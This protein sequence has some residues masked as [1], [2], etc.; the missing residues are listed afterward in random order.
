[1]P[2]LSG[3]VKLETNYRKQGKPIMQ[4]RLEISVW[5]VQSLAPKERDWMWG[6]YLRGMII[7]V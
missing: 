7:V 4:A 5:L 3:R 6:E 2:L 1:M